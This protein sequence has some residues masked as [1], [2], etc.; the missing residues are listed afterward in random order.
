MG[1]PGI[2][3]SFFT[4]ITLCV[5]VFG[6]IEAPAESSTGSLCR[7][8]FSHLLWLKKIFKREIYSKLLFSA[9]QKHV[10]LNTVDINSK[11]QKELIFP[12]CDRNWTRERDVITVS[13]SK[14]IAQSLSCLISSA[15][16]QGGLCPPHA[17]V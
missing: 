17:V 14:V 7:I 1:F 9:H 2:S 11:L 6:K 13:F 4:C 15:A 5:N 10:P 3:F 12:A 16:L 8:L